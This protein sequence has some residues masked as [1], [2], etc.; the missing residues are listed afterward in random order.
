MEEKGVASLLGDCR[1]WREPAISEEQKAVISPVIELLKDYKIV[2]IGE[3]EFH[4]IKLADWLS[5]E[6]VLFALRQ[7]RNT[8][9]RQLEGDY[10]QLKQLGLKPGTSLFF[11]GAEVTKEKGFGRFN[12]AGYW[13]RK[14][15]GKVED[16][17]WFILT[18]LP[19]IA[20]VLEV[21]RARMGIEAMFKDCQTG[22]Y[23][24]A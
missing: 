5:G 15:R 7:K 18:N 21:Y 12:L 16:E 11:Q 23:N 13:K 3:R 14:Y 17:G 4:S 1:T 6:K 20:E 10:Q 8:Y 22:G 2:I 9:I 19:T 24:L